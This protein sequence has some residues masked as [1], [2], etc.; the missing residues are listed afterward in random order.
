M[1]LFLLTAPLAHYYFH[2]A[3]HDP[4][5]VV[6]EIAYYDV[7]VYG[8]GAVILAGTLSSFFTGR[9]ETRV[10]MIIDTLAAA[11]N[12]VLA[13]LWIFGHCGFPRWGIVGAARRRSVRNGPACWAMRP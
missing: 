6:E 2:H 11:F 8:S 10:V 1:P 13:W 12:G 5:V 7:L 3:G 4:D 9:G